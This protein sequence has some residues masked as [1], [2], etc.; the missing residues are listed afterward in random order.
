MEKIS[1]KKSQL[2]ILKVELEN[3]S[4]DS[5]DPKNPVSKVKNLRKG[6]TSVNPP[7]H[8]I[9]R[10]GKAVVAADEEYWND[11]LLPPEVEMLCQSLGSG[12]PHC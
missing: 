11:A 3:S 10:K 4:N 12:R 7:K 6:F 8:V 9:S 1:E 5:K 2:K